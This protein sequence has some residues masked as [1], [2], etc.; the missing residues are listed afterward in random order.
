MTK[1]LRKRSFT[2]L[3]IMIVIFLIGIIGSVIGYN[4][5]G[6]LE[7][8]KAF[9]TEQAMRQIEDSLSL[10]LAE[11]TTTPEE[12]E[13]DLKKAL[14]KSGL[15]KKADEIAKDGWGTPFVVTLDEDNTI[16]VF[17]KNYEKYLEKN[18]K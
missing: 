7:K 18:K 14:E 12:I 8:G 11:G 10:M 1:T 3:E 6:S 13:S 15:F 16:K 17:S 5:K 9:R 4:M 2:L